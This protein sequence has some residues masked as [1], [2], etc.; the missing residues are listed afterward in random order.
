[1]FDEFR[2]KVLDELITWDKKSAELAR[3]ATRYHDYLEEQ[4]KLFLK[5]KLVVIEK[6]KV[7]D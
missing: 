5:V 4:R 3:A 1:M 6:D 2:L 7:I